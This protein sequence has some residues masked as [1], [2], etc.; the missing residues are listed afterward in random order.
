MYINTTKLMM[1]LFTFRPSKKI[2][3]QVDWCLWVLNVKRAWNG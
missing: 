3:G 2:A 1:Q